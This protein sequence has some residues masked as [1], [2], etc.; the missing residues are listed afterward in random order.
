[1]SPDAPPA[2]AARTAFACSVDLGLSLG[3]LRRGTGD[4]TYRQTPDGAIW[5]GC[6]TPHGPGTVRVRRAGPL[7]EID[8]WGDGAPW[9]IKQ[10]PAMVGAEDD[11]GG[12]AAL[13]AAHP[14]LR[15][16]HRAHPGLRIVRTGLVMH[17]LVPA[18]LEQKVTT[19]EA[20][21]A[22]H[23]LVTRYGDPAPGP[24]PAG[25]RVPPEPHAWAMVPSWE[26]HQ[27]GVDAK[28]AGTLVRAARRASALERT[29]DLPPDDA[30]RCLRAIPG[31]GVWTAAETMQRAHGHADS[32]SVGD[33][34]LSGQ[35]GYALLGERDA[36]DARMLEL[37]APFRPH[38]HRAA[39]L[40]LLAGPAR[41]RRGPRLAPADHRGR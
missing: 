35:I 18:V 38:R 37:L 34:H 12:F 5:R 7:V 39:R 4:P 10:G 31:I 22:W 14:L 8:A 17:S 32:L 20:F 36:D 28:R 26:W 40:L 15:E 27:A 9:L 6:R 16:A 41:P 30:A 23:R 2:P 33:Y 11:L 1:M 13:A 25:L 3:V 24:V 19:G 29:A 21:R